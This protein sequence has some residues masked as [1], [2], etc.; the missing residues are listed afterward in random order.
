VVGRFSDV[1]VLA[2]YTRSAHETFIRVKNT[3]GAIRA[4]MEEPNMRDPHSP[5]R[6]AAKHWAALAAEVDEK[7]EG[8]PPR[9]KNCG[10]PLS[11]FDLM[12]VQI[13]FSSIVLSAL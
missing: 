2:G 8:R 13:G 3:G 7:K 5:G 4:W 9:R 12:Q 1:V 11:Q 10:V 6:K